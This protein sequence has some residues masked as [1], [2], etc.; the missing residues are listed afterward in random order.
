M[1]FCSKDSASIT[2]SVRRALKRGVD[3]GTLEFAAFV[4][5]HRRRGLTFSFPHGTG[6]ASARLRSRRALPPFRRISFQFLS[7]RPM[8]FLKLTPLALEMPA[9]ELLGRARNLS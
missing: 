8:P 5:F 3:H 1:G 9:P 4:H 2:G 7:E 6:Y